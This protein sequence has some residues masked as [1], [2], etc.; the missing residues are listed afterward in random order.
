M[1][2]TLA[3]NR[4]MCWY[5]HHHQVSQNQQPKQLVTSVN[6]FNHDDNS[7]TIMKQV[8]QPWLTKGAPVGQPTG[9]CVC[10]ARRL[11]PYK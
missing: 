8:N 10:V 2:S 11:L 5:Y 9:L 4:V 3:M 7:L 1:V 6:W